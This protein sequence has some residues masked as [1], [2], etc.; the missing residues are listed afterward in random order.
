MEAEAQLSAL[1]QETRFLT[2]GQLESGDN[3]TLT[4]QEASNVRLIRCGT[5]IDMESQVS[6]CTLFESVHGSRHSRCVQLGCAGSVLTD[7]HRRRAVGFLPDGQRAEAVFHVRSL[8]MFSLSDS[9]FLSPETLQSLQIVRSEVHPNF[10]MSGPHS[11][12]AGSKESLSIYGLFCMHA[13]TPQGRVLLRRIL[14][15]PIL[16]LDLL[17]G[18]QR[19]VSLFSRP[20]NVEF[21]REASILLRKVK[22]GRSM[23]LQLRK[24]IDP[25]SSTRSINGGV[26][27]G[28][29]NLASH[30]LRLREMMNHLS[31]ADNVGI[32]QKVRINPYL[33]TPAMVASM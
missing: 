15:H 2:S 9:M 14:M 19:T 32:V 22:N 24:G 31:G 28:L 4:G 7:L 33:H 10:Q 25:S 3:D 11:G 27:S 12:E 13:C 20:D 26:W 23:V 29:T 8:R 5:Q 18:R 30:A 17:R 21:V 1:A 16:D 6:V